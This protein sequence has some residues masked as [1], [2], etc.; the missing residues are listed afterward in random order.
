MP[1]P[2]ATRVSHSE[3]LL[4]KRLRSRRAGKKPARQPPPNS[5][6][7]T[8]HDEEEREEDEE[9][10][11]RAAG[12]GS[13]AEADTHKRT[14]GHFPG[15]AADLLGE[16]AFHEGGAGFAHFLHT[17]CRT[18]EALT[19]AIDELKTRRQDA[20][21]RLDDAHFAQAEKRSRPSTNRRSEDDFLI[22]KGASCSTIL[23]SLLLGWRCGKKHFHVFGHHQG[24]HY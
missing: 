21:K 20:G 15:L 13:G 1:S 14:D 24:F 8:E 17:N 6:D 18:A 3:F 9:D 12:A 10:D 7:D 4:A 19:S 5:D 23:I 11:S 2:A 16:R 22:I